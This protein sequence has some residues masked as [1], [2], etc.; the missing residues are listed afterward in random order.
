MDKQKQIT[1]LGNQYCYN[2]IRL[3][4]A[5]ANDHMLNQEITIPNILTALAEIQS[6]L[7]DF[8]ITFK[9]HECNYLEYWKTNFNLRIEKEK[10]KERRTNKEPADLLA[11][12]S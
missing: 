2:M 4:T 3:R 6:E 9:G 12:L 1:K 7:E 5:V 8:G 10:Q 11:L